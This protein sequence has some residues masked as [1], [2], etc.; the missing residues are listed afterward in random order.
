MSSSTF[1]I[2]YQRDQVTCSVTG[3][4]TVFM[5]LFLYRM[6]FFSWKIYKIGK[7]KEKLYDIQVIICLFLVILHEWGLILLDYKKAFFNWFSVIFAIWA[8]S[9]HQSQEPADV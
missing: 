2:L 5:C 1:E 9:F 3:V 7:W 6:F 4:S 8:I